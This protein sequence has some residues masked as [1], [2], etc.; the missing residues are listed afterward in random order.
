M[1]L[2]VIHDLIGEMGT[3]LLG[4]RADLVLSQWHTAVRAVDVRIHAGTRLQLEDSAGV[5]ERPDARE[6]HV[7]V[8][9]Q[10]FGAQLQHRPQIRALGQGDADVGGQLRQARPLEQGGLRP[11]ALAP[12]LGV[13]QLPLDGRNQ[14]PQIPLGEKVLRAR[15][16]RFDRDVFADRARDEDEGRIEI[17]RP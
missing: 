12:H 1:D 2:G 16:H 17:A 6:R 5:V 8:A 15:F 11:A 4:D 3:A 7:E 10:R 13:A 14:A 9:H